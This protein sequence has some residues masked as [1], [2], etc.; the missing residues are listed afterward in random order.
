MTEQ[1]QNQEAEKLTEMTDSD[2]PTEKRI[3]HLAEKA[4]EKSTKTEQHYDKK[5]PLFSK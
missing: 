1:F 2:A 3:D 4:A 5:T